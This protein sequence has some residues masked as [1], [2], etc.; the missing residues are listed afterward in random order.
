MLSETGYLITVWIDVFVCEQATLTVKDP[1]FGFD[2]AFYLCSVIERRR[3][4]DL[5]V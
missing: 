4:V 3:V 1:L 5:R 2:V